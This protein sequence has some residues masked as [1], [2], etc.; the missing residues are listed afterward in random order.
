ML[1]FTDLGGSFEGAFDGY[2]CVV[3]REKGTAGPNFHLSRGLVVELLSLF[4]EPVKL[5]TEVASAG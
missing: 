1:R 5:K 2:S 3:V 4:P